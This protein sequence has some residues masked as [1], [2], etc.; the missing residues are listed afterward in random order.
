MDLLEYGSANVLGEIKNCGKWSE[1]VAVMLPEIMYFEITLL[2]H[3]H[4]LPF[5]WREGGGEVEPP[6]KFS[7]RVGGL[8]RKSGIFNDSKSLK[9]KIFFSTKTK[10]SNS[11]I[12]RI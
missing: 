7:K 4:P 2:K 10:N 1:I 3:V 9:V 8:D 11:E 6:T 12:L 5:C